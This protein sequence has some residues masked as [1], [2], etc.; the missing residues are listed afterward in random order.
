M[1]NHIQ[2]KMIL[3]RANVKL[4]SITE[5]TPDTP[6][7]RLMENVLAGFAQFDNEVRTERCVGGMKAKLK[8][9]I[10]IYE[11]PLGYMKDKNFTGKG[12]RPDIPDPI[13]FDK[14]QKGWR[15]MLSGNYRSVEVLKYFHK[16]GVTSRTG[17][18]LDSQAISAMFRN[19]FYAGILFVDVYDIHVK[20][21]HKPMITEDEFYKV[22]AIIA[23]QNNNAAVK[24]LGFNSDFPL[25]KIIKCAG[26]GRT[27][28]GAWSK[29]KNRFG[30]YSCRRKY[31]TDKEN[32]TKKQAEVTFLEFLSEITPSPE[33][34]DLYKEMVTE[35]YLKKLKEKQEIQGFIKGELKE[36]EDRMKR[37]EELL[38]SGTYS[39]DKFKEKTKPL[40][41][42]IATKRIQLSEIN[43]DT[44]EYETCVNYAMN[45]LQLLPEYWIALPEKEKFKLHQ[46]IFPEGL[47]IENSR[48]TTDELC[49]Y[50]KDIKAI[51]EGEVCFGARGRT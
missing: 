38:E 42:E 15:M 22:Q 49:L 8:Q 29:E 43:I 11:P 30:Y 9:G 50:H 5:E 2:I 7:G 1:E 33:L 6:S 34:S 35:T 47:Y 48:V 17:R 46:I 16:N 45:F 21:K 51:S 24:H 27:I 41:N 14:I 31:C 18:T 19:K 10:W 4:I 28:T 40:V 37:L 25:N 36:L 44:N 3:S 26:C 13:R 12:A 39:I 23:S 20:G 32:I